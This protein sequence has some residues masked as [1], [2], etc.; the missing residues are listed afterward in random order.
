M[1]YYSPYT[2]KYVQ[3]IFEAMNRVG[4]LKKTGDP[5]N[6]TDDDNE[7]PY[8][9]ND[10]ETLND[11]LKHFVVMP[12]NTYNYLNGRGFVNTGF[13]PYT[14]KIIDSTSSQWN[15]MG[16]RGIQISKEGLKLMKQEASDAHYLLTRKP[17]EHHKPSTLTML[18]ISI[19][20]IFLIYISA[21]VFSLAFNYQQWNWFSKVFFIFFLGWH[22]I[23]AFKRNKH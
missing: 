23:D 13:C 17:L 20:K 3:N 12:L 19:I 10:F 15:Y 6:P 18:F 8:T 11:F 4:F 2:E 7:E 14:G 5:L 16:N 21:C 9:P 1:K 22:I